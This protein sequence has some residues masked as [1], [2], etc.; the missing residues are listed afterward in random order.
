MKITYDPE[1]DALY[2]EL[3]DAEPAD[4]MDIEE[5]VTA[6]PDADGHIVGLEVLDAG[7]RMGIGAMESI[8]LE[9]VTRSLRRSA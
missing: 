7:E 1:V 5:G 8:S 9:V 2:A 3:R 4:S 6:D